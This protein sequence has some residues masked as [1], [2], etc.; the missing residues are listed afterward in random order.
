MNL[1]NLENALRVADETFAE[2]MKMDFLVFG[3][4]LVVLAGA[5]SALL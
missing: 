4:L 5:L 1:A 2:K 3:S